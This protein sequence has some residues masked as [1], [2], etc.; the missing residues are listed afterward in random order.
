MFWVNLLIAQCKLNDIGR[1]AL[2]FLNIQE[3]L[4]RMDFPDSGLCN[5]EGNATT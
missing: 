3:P 4:T 2:F 1:Y 5:T